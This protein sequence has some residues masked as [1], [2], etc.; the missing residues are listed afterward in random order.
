MA[1]LHVLETF[2]FATDPS[3]VETL[4][5]VTVLLVSLVLAACYLPALSASRF[6]PAG[7]LRSE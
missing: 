2:L 6:D 1:T 7:V 5:G 4:T 3:D